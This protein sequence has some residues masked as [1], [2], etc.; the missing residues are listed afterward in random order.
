MVVRA[1]P[2]HLTTDEEMKLLPVT[3]RVKAVLPA[4][5]DEGLRDEAA[6]AG[7]FGT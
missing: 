1:V 6:G 5:Q 3:V 4:L 7:L 2:F